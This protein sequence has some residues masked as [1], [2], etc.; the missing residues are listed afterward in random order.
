MALAGLLVFRLETAAF[1]MTSGVGSMLPKVA[2]I[3]SFGQLFA[4]LLNKDSNRQMEI[5]SHGFQSG[6]KF[7]SFIDQCLLLLVSLHMLWPLEYFSLTKL[8][9]TI[10]SKILWVRDK[11]T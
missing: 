7:K 6:H 11:I 1:I 10:H 5:L 2:L 9:V 3:S 8:V 4:P